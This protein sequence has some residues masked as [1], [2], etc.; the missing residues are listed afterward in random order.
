VP[1]QNSCKILHAQFLESIEKA[2]LNIKMEIPGAKSR[3][4]FFLI[5]FQ[6]GK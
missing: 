6:P 3:T 5:E 1:E 2:I 4:K